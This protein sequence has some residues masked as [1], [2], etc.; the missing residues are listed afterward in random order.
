MNILEEA[1][2]LRRRVQEL[3]EALAN[4]RKT[5]LRPFGPPTDEEVERAVNAHKVLGDRRSKMRA[6][7]EAA[8][9]PDA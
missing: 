1:A 7:L 3:E 5:K 4:E 8:R 2:E 9:K 6:A